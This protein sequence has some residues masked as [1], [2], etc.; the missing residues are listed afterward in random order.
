MA[1]V[2]S[3]RLFPVQRARRR[4][5]QERSALVNP[6]DP[7]VAPAAAFVAEMA[8]DHVA[9]SAASEHQ[10]RGEDREVVAVATLA[11]KG[12]RRRAPQIASV[13]VG[14]VAQGAAAEGLPHPTGD[15]I[16]EGVLDHRP[17]QRPMKKVDDLMRADEILD[18]V[19][20]VLRRDLDAPAR[21]ARSLKHL[22]REH[23]I[24][25]ITTL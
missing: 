20:A 25:T 24:D 17:A 5:Q 19:A 16:G 11:L 12:E 8:D 10:R 3:G 2:A 15:S 4:L 23:D 6:F 7:G 21:S 9:V 14:D 13:R 22:G 18:G 1:D